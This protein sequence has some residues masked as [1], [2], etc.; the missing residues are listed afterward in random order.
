VRIGGGG[1]GGTWTPRGGWKKEGG[2]KFPVSAHPFV[3]SLT[4]RDKR[5]RGKVVE[6]RGRNHVKNRHLMAIVALAS[7]RT[8]S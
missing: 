8:A 6:A 2:A 4:K 7:N 3:P 5:S 1:G